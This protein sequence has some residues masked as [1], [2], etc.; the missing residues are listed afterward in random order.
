MRLTIALGLLAG[1]APLV[2]LLL[3]ERL[4]LRRELDSRWHS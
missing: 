2:L 1:V 4:M 3:L